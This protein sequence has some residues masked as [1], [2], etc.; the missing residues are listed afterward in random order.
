MNNIEDEIIKIQEDMEEI[1]K[2]IQSLTELVREIEGEIVSEYNTYDIEYDI[3]NL[4][5]T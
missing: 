5:H 3:D 4:N 1:K 2:E